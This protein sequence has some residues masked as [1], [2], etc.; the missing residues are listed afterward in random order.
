MPRQRVFYVKNRSQKD[1]EIR[2][3][4]VP[5]RGPNTLT[6]MGAGYAIPMRPSKTGCLEIVPGQSRYT[7]PA[8]AVMR[9]PPE[10]WLIPGRL[11]NQPFLVEITE[12]EYNRAPVTKPKAAPKKK[13]KA[14]PKGD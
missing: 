13:A 10:W 6:P 8:G 3:P 4:R 9:L 7:I 1:E 2:L 14:K 5:A 12:A 11:K